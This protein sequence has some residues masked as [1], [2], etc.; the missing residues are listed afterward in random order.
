VTHR[1]SRNGR[2]GLMYAQQQAD[3]VIPPRLPMYGNA[4]FNTD[5]LVDEP[6]IFRMSIHE[7]VDTTGGISPLMNYVY[8]PEEETSEGRITRPYNSSTRH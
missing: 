8:G 6:D 5:A 7:L 1:L 2:S 4:D 3:A